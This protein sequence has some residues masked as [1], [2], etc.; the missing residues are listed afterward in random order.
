MRQLAVPFVLAA[1][2]APSAHGQTLPLPEGVY[3]GTDTGCADGHAGNTVEFRPFN[4]GYL[5]RWVT[6]YE[7]LSESVPGAGPDMFEAVAVQG[8][9]MPQS[10]DDPRP[11]RIELR[12]DGEFAMIEADGTFYPHLR[13]CGPL[14][15]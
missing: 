3:V 4:D 6:C 14:V 1:F 13:R 5:L 12:G 2:L 15:D 7:L 9:P 10:Q 11:V 8:S